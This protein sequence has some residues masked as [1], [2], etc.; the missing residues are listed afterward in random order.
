MKKKE[1]GSDLQK[2]KEGP[3]EEKEEGRDKSWLDGLPED[4]STNFVGG[5]RR[6]I[7]QR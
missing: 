3:K 2:V 7:C 1:E 4:C 5:G 6:G